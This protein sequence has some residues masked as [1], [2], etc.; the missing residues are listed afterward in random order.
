MPLE[1]GMKK[2][3]GRKKGSINK[4]TET[5]LA[6]VRYILDKGE[7]DIDNIWPEL[8]PK[9][10]MEA[11]IKLLEYDLPKH[12]RIENVGKQQPDITINFIAASPEKLAEQNTIDIEH[13]EIDEGHSD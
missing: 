10:Q 1:K 3:G 11:I 13:E 8:K 5:K 12:S 6:F 4:N 2:T 7:K 9:E